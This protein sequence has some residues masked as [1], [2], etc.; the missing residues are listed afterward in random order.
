VHGPRGQRFPEVGQLTSLIRPISDIEFGASLPG[1][2]P[3]TSHSPIRHHGVDMPTVLS[4]SASPQPASRTHALL[5]HVNQRLST[6]G[7][8]VRTLQVRELPAIALLGGDATHPELTAAIHAVRDADALVVVTP[9]YQSAYSGLLKL[10]L[11]LLPQFALRGKTVLPLAVGGSVA[12]VLAVDYAL[13]PVLATL[14]AAH[15]TPGWF[16]PSGHIR[17]YRDGGVLLD[18][19]SLTPI[20][21]I[22]DGFLA[23]LSGDRS[24]LRPERVD[25]TAGSRVSPEVGSAPAVVE[26][27]HLE[28]SRVDPGDPRLRPLKIDLAIEYG[29]RYGQE[30]AQTLLTEVS[31]TDFTEPHGA[32][33]L[34]AECGETIAGGAV[35][36]DNKVTAEVM[37]VWTAIRHRRRGLGRRLMAELEAV[38]AQ[39]GYRRIHLSMGTRQPEARDLCLATGYTPWFDLTVDPEIIGPL[40]FSKELADDK[41]QA[42]WHAT[43]ETCSP[44]HHEDRLVRQ[45][46]AT[47]L[48]P[49]ARRH[50]HS[51]SVNNV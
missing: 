21:Q 23:A 51:R 25:A 36:R 29:T 31:S 12:H 13:R 39:L 27:A 3:L 38:A 19:A 40:R 43:S 4:I 34:L 5:T 45:Q 14:G 35:R 9:V 41:Q 48:G 42:P 18:P 8:N 10:F 28:V 17:V 32:F 50:L 6:A 26:S 7:H 37:W 15:V 44:P 46:S 16:V 2:N 1:P 30:S 24:A 20:T 47:F 33:L 11:D 22:T 49:G